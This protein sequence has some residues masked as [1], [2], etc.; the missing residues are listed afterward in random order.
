[1][2][3]AKVHPLVQ[4][5]VELNSMDSLPMSI[6]SEHIDRNKK[7]LKLCN[8]NEHEYRIVNINKPQIFS[9]RSNF[10]KTSKYSLITFFPI[11]LFEEFHYK[12]KIANL[13]FLFISSM[14]CI[15]LITN[16]NGLPTTLIPLTFVV[17]VS[18]I[19]SILEDI[20]RHHADNE[21]NS[22]KILV[23]NS[24]RRCFED[25]QWNSLQVGDIVKVLNREQIPADL[26]ILG[27]NEQD[28]ENPTGVCYVETKKL[29]WG[30][31]PQTPTMRTV[32]NRKSQRRR[33]C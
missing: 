18:A 10:V 29:G 5:E 3:K 20:Q 8:P 14:Q 15:P 17:L 33:R 30:D 11:F 27:V 13:Y 32:Y 22:R 25:T 16:T 6:D 31:K 23:Y 28:P 26:C 1:M 12:K 19:F 9:F 4:P 24:E 2:L 21:A 7:K